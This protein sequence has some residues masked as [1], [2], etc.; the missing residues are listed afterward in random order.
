[1]LADYKR[2]PRA[3]RA[4]VISS[5]NG[6]AAD[7]SFFHWTLEF[8]QV[9]DDKNGGFDIVLGNPPWEMVQLD[10]QEFFMTSAPHIANAANM[11]AREKLIAK[12]DLDEPNLYKEY[13]RGRLEIQHRRDTMI[14][15]CIGMRQPGC[16]DG[17]LDRLNRR[18]MGLD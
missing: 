16:Y 18:A 5:A 3:V 2:N 11:A 1:M 7:V 13:L 4:D 10:P 6:L 8:P 15:L 14:G 17:I 12:L 9:F